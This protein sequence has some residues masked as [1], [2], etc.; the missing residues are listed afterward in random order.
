[1]E[2]EQRFVTFATNMLDYVKDINMKII[3]TESKTMLQGLQGRKI[4]SFNYSAS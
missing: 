2:I 4:P 3:A 1:M